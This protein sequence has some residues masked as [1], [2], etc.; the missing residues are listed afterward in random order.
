MTVPPGRRR[1]AEFAL[2]GGKNAA[3]GLHTARGKKII[4]L[5]ECPVAVPKISDLLP[6]LRALDYGVGLGQIASNIR[7]TQIDSGIDILLISKE[8]REPTL[9]CRQKLA[10][11]AESQNLARIAWAD[12]N[13]SEP[14]AVRRRPELR[15]GAAVLHLPERYFLQPSIEGEK[16]IVELASRAIAGAD[17]LA[18]LYAG[19]GSF[20]FPL[21][22]KTKVTAFELD[23]AMVNAAKQAA[24]GLSLTVERRDL[25]R[26]PLTECE[27]DHFDAIIFD[28]PRAGAR[29]QA[30]YLARSS[31][32]TIVAVSCNPNTLARD[33]RIL[34]N[35]G[36][37]IEQIV[38]IDQFTW[39]AKLEAIAVLRR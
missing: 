18:D 34:S 36:Y 24:S 8:G 37:Q 12:Q 3:I 29:D 10:A 11:F 22:N 23:A 7:I 15:L 25:A 13:G 16:V 20:S 26:S 1:R 38:P 31:V 35:G 21:A 39:S 17:S 33:L 14:L 19:L 6:K 27:L 30:D 28:P 32:P 5:Q 4:D 2:S 9:A